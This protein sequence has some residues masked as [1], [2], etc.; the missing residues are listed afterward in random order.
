MTNYGQGLIGFASDTCIPFSYNI[1]MIRKYVTYKE[2]QIIYQKRYSRSVK[3]CWIA[4]IRSKHGK[5]TR[6]APNR[7]GKKPKYPCPDYVRP[8]LEKILKEL[9]M[10]Q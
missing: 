8:K 2:A 1:E 6:K 7:I 5:T 9:R 3:T 10:I 4:D